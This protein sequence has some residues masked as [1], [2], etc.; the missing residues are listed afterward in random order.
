MYYCCVNNFYANVPVHN[1]I[2]IDDREDVN[3]SVKKNSAHLRVHRITLNNRFTILQLNAVSVYIN[4]NESAVCGHATRADRRESSLRTILVHYIY[5][6]IGPG[7]KQ[8]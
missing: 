4:H 5:Y 3:L 2:F 8:R 7:T 6:A 1:Q